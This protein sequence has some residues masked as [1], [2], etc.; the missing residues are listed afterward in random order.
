MY[1]ELAG[2]YNRERALR[3]TRVIRRNLARV[4]QIAADQGIPTQAA[5]G[6]LAEE[7]IRSM[8]GLRSHHWGRF[9]SPH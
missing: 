7:R 9:I 2:P 6:H 4:F 8:Q 3:M 5:A 1:N